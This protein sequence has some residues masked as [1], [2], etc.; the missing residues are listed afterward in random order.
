MILKEH[1]IIGNDV[2]VISGDEIMP[3]K[4]VEKPFFDPRK[5]TARS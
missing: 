2:E 1:S 5:T 4:V 3:A